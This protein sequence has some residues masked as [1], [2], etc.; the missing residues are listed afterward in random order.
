MADGGIVLSG[1]AETLGIGAMTDGRW[2]RFAGTMAAAGVYPPGLDAKRA[3]SL[4]FVNR[5]VGI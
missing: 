1:D 4:R 2:E 5:K 3:Y